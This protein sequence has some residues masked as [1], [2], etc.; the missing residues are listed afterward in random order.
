MVEQLAA[1]G[2]LFSDD[3]ASIK[4]DAI[5]PAHKEWDRIAVTGLGIRKFPSNL[6]VI[7]HQSVADRKKAVAVVHDIG[8][9]PRKYNPANWPS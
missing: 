9:A 4:P 5:A 8:E 7:A 6:G 1:N 2:V 3:V